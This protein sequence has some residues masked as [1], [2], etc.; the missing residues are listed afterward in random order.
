MPI[1][2]RCK[3]CQQLLGISVSR[4]GAVVDCPQCGRSLRVPELDG[5]IRKLPNAAAKTKG[6]SV[7]ISALSELSALNSTDVV[8][9]QELPINAATPIAKSSSP[10]IAVPLA[11]I[12][13]DD[14]IAAVE[15]WRDA[16]LDF[17]LH[18][19]PVAINDSLADL[20]IWDDNVATTGVS[21]DILAEIRDAN[22]SERWASIRTTMFGIV[23]MLIGLAVGWWLKTQHESS[24]NS[25]VHNEAPNGSELI[26]EHRDAQ[27]NPDANQT[28]INRGIAHGAVEYIDASGEVMPDS[29]STILLLPTVRIGTIKFDGRSLKRSIG[30]PDRSATEAALATIGGFV[31]QADEL[32]Q[33]S[34]PAGLNTTYSMI[35]I[36]RHQSRPSD[37]EIIQD[38]E[39][40]LQD[41][42]ES[43]NHLCG[44]LAVKI[45]KLAA[46]SSNNQVDFRFNET[47]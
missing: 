33:F 45:T 44:K 7:L 23:A 9:E 30:D 42:F 39:T 46:V 37:V 4:A 36:S 5:K 20:A 38:V 6:D 2:F 12:P 31:T 43:S 3:H 14:P 17:D 22:R 19:S 34:I 40:V 10:P 26:A 41:Y 21:N 35:A 1:K 47:R 29:G 24:T 27:A 8:S 18:N 25:A 28:T 32:G 16:P 13:I 15:E 11:K